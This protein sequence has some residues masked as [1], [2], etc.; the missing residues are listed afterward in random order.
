MS[1]WVRRQSPTGDGA[2]PQN[3]A[4][5]YIRDDEIIAVAETFIGETWH[6][7]EEALRYAVALDSLWHDAVEGQAARQL[8]VNAALALSES[9][10]LYLPQM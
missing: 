5:L 9:G 2:V 3:T 10:P 7:G 4:E 1:Q 6:R 8:I